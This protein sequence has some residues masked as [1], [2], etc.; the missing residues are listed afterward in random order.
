MAFFSLTDNA[1]M[2]LLSGDLSHAITT[3]NAYLTHDD[4]VKRS[5]PA[6][7]AERQHPSVTTAVCSTRE[8]LQP[9]VA[10]PWATR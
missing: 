10:Q 8:D 7:R 6:Q 1:F 4:L 5:Y 9:R 2:E 3:A